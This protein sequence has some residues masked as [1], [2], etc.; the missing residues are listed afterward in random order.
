MT[1]NELLA[2][3]LD[4]ILGFGFYEGHSLGEISTRNLDGVEL[5]SEEAQDLLAKGNTIMMF[6]LNDP[7]EAPKELK[8]M[9]FIEELIKYEYPDYPINI[10][11]LSDEQL[12]N[13]N[14]DVQG[15]DYLT[16]AA[17][18]EICFYGEVTYG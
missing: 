7:D 15:Y 8:L 16:G 5:G 1:R 11:E 6:D 9:T 13:F 3:L 4:N 12:E 17:V 10:V 14:N 18:L 2:E